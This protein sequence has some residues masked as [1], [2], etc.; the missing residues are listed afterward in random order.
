MRRAI[1]ASL[2]TLRSRVGPRGWSARSTG[3]DEPH[4]N[5]ETV[6]SRTYP[7]QRREDARRDPDELEIAVATATQLNE[8]NARLRDELGRF[9]AQEQ[10]T[11]AEQKRRSGAEILVALDRSR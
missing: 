1:P 10:I 11:V 5:S 8:E 2:R 3:P 9:Q 6:A 4:K 7:S